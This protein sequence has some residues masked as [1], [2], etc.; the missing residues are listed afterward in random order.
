VPRRDRVTG[1]APPP[2]EP[3]RVHRCPSCGVGLHGKARRQYICSWCKGDPEHGC[4]NY[5]N[6]IIDDF[7]ARICPPAMTRVQVRDMLLEERRR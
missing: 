3:S 1:D 6:D 4:D 5:F 2:P 7:M